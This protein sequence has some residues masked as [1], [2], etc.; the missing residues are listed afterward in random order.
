MALLRTCLAR[1][2]V[3][4][5]GGVHAQP[6]FRSAV[7]LVTVPVAVTQRQA[8]A[9]RALLAELRALYTIGFTPAKAADGR[10]RRLRVESRIRSLQ[11]RHRGGYLATPKAP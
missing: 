7:D 2:A 5:S 8:N 10:Y 9:A 1:A 3:T 11:V 4:L 6:V